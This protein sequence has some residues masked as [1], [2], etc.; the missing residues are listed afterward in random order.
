MGH[1]L[2]LAE[3]VPWGP[4]CPLQCTEAPVSGLSP[5]WQFVLRKAGLPIGQE[6]ELWPQAT[7][8]LQ[9]KTT[10]TMFWAR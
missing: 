10:L 1:R 9:E 6:S 4:K 5:P 3:A 8:L 7:I 2:V